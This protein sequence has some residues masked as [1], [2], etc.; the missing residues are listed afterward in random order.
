MV[1]GNI[2]YKLV[3]DISSGKLLT[4]NL[5]LKTSEYLN[6]YLVVEFT[7][8]NNSNNLELQNGAGFSLVYTQ[9]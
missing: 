8:N 2:T 4:S 7:G 1:C 9:I 6:F 3:T 5:V